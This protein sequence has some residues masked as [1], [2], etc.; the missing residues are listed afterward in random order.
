MNY[1]TVPHDLKLSFGELQIKLPKQLTI[2]SAR[3][4]LTETKLSKT[5]LL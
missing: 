4:E 2:R 5:Q 1:E 3:K